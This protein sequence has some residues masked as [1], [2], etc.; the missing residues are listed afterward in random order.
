WVRVAWVSLAL[1]FVI[2]GA[3]DLDL[4]PAEARL[5]LA[6]GER[7]EPLGQVFGYWAP[8]LWPAPVWPSIVL[9]Q[10]DPL[11]RP[12]SPAVRWPAAFGGLIAGWMVARRILQM[13]GMRAAVL[14]GIGWFGSLAMIDHSGAFGLDLIV[15]LATLATIDRLMAGRSD[16]V[17]GLW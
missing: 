4:G 6:A 8:D 1:I 14:G 3:I 12:S 15:G 2:V 11:G 5:G 9:A 7:P 16:S 10:L 13:L 17:A